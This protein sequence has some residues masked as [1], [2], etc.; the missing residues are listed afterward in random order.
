[1]RRLA[2]DWDATLSRINVSSVHF[3]YAI[4]LALVERFTRAI[5]QKLQPDLSAQSISEK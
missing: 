4:T 5:I 3:N 1:L 2:D